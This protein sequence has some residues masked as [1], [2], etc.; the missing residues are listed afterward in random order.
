MKRLATFATLLLAVPILMAM[1]HRA[2]AVPPP[3][4][5]KAPVTTACLMSAY[6]GETTAHSKYAAYAFKAEQEG[7]TDVARLFR[8]VAASEQVHARN[9]RH[10][11]ARLGIRHPD[12]GAFTEE[13][14][15][16]RDNL[17]DAIQGENHEIRSMYPKFIREAKLEG[18]MDAA[19]SFEYALSAERQHAALFREALKN[20]GS[21]PK[22]TVYYVNPTC[23]S[24][25]ANRPPA[26]C[27]VCGTPRAHFERIE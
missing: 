17:E 9:H 20:L 23:G 19:R 3:E 22:G 1:P 13:N 25:Y 10:A 2:T 26:F 21:K 16:T 12:V 4:A 24:T 7:Y 8:A 15:S 6:K 11:L 27:P 18:Q 14:L 5:Q